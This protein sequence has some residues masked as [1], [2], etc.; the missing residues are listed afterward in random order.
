MP[1]RPELDVEGG[2]I[3]NREYG[4]NRQSLL[5]ILHGVLLRTRCKDGAYRKVG[6]IWPWLDSRFGANFGFAVNLTEF[7]KKP[8]MPAFGKEIPEDVQ[9]DER[10]SIFDRRADE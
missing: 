7:W 8:I 9:R 6:Q 2:N 4:H 5:P 3:G 1:D 10:H